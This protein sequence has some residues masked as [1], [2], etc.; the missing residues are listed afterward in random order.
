MCGC[1]VKYERFL[2]DNIV[3]YMQAKADQLLFLAV[4]LQRCP[5]RSIATAH[6]KQTVRIGSCCAF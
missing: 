1:D 3:I 2:I 5:I 6:P 4:V